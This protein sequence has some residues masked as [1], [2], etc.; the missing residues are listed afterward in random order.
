MGTGTLIGS[1]VKLSSIKSLV[2]ECAGSLNA[3]LEFAKDAVS[4]SYKGE[5]CNGLTEGRGTAKKTR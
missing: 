2:P 1:A 3:S 5:D 4:W